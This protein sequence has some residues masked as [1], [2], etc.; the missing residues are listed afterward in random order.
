MMQTSA[1]T[2]KVWFNV[3]K[4]LSRAPMLLLHTGDLLVEQGRL[5]H[6]LVLHGYLRPIGCSFTSA[7][8]ARRVSGV[9]L[10]SGEA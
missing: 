6:D 9:S 4:S 10:L 1:V 7:V 3:A 8:P 5:I 2:E